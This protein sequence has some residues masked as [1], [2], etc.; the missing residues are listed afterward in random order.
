MTQTRNPARARLVLVLFLVYASTANAGDWDITPRISLGEIFSDNI[1]LDDDDKKSDLVTDISPG[2]SIHGEGGRLKADIDYEMQNLIFLNETGASGSNHLLDAKATAELAKRLFFVDA[3][4]SMGQTIIDANRSISN[5]NINNSGNRTDYYFYSLSPYLTPHFGGFA[6]GLFRYTYSQVNYSE[7]ASDA[8][9]NSFRAGL[10][11]GRNFGPLSWAANYNYSDEQRDSA[12]DETWEN[13]DGSARYRI[14]STFSL[15]GQVGY[16]NNDYETSEQI[17]NGSYWSVGGFLQPNR[18]YSL[19]AQDGS[20]LTTATVGLYPTRR[21]SLVVTYRDRQVGLNPG[22]VWSGSFSHYTRRTTWNASYLED[23]TTQQQELLQDGG[24]TFLGIDPVTGEVN[25]NPQPG[26]LIVVAPVG[27]V[28]S[29]TNEVIERKRASGTFGIKTGKTGLRFTVFDERRKY[30]TSLREEDTKGFSG[31]L[32]RRLAPRTNGILTG[33]YQRIKDTE[34]DGN[35]EDV[36]AFIRADVTRQMSPTVTGSL[37][38]QISTQDSNEDSR[39]YTENR[40]EARLTK[41]F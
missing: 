27:P 24:F 11:S 28:R 10:V 16:A 29:L 1:N 21:T 20:N 13:A 6:D 9:I 36:Y 23:T 40:I 14:S 17:E 30:L 7:G 32:N 33:S 31:S 15:V 12:T 26:D 38:Y 5:N 4:S 37:S 22:K 25:S 41:L 34:N 3:D 2:V 19:E 35:L 39:D 18:Y 8:E